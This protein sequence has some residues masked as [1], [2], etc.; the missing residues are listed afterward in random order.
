MSLM[1]D[2]SLVLRL[3]WEVASPSMTPA[4]GY[5]GKP[6][7]ML[8]ALECLGGGLYGNHGIAHWITQKTSHEDNGS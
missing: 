2:W 7:I 8:H 5:P 6:T 3:P 1:A 4:D